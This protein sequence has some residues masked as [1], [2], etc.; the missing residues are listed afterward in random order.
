MRHAVL[1]RLA[2][3][4]LYGLATAVVAGLG[5]AVYLDSALVRLDLTVVRLLHRVGSDELTALAN[6]VTTLAST[7]SVLLVAA[8]AAAAMLVRGH[9]PGALAVVL[10]VGATQGIVFAIKELVARAR[11]P[12]S[13]AWIDAAG[14][15]FPSAHAA[16]GVAL[17]GLL[18][19]YTVQR[20]HGRARVAAG[21]VALVGVGSIGLTRVY[22]GAHYPS[23]VLAGWLVGA[24]VAAAAWQLA[25][26]LRR[27]RPRA[28]LTA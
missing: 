2:G 25:R 27:L 10:T 16:S 9:W 15:A 13:S 12:A 3:A 5:L 17:Y 26:A 21:A 18:A 23:D 4:P 7:T 14:H 19:L 11:P 1:K 28:A 20:L 22:L 6:G 8:V 24:V